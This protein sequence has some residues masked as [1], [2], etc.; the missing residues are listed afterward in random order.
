MISL[1]GT[2]I[3]RIAFSKTLYEDKGHERARVQ[4]LLKETQAM[5][6]ALFLSDYFPYMGWVDK[7]TGKI[8]RLEKNF[9]EMDVFYQ[10]IIDEH[11]DP[12]RPKPTQED[13][14]D[15]LLQIYKDRSFKVQLTFKHIK[16]ILRCKGWARSCMASVSSKFEMHL[17]SFTLNVLS[18]SLRSSPNR[19]SGT[20]REGPEPGPEHQ[21]ER[22]KA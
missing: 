20:G 11:L 18:R 6:G 4:E 8:S 21:Q 9:K 12:K 16:A 15:V 17:V 2:L 10:E 22:L 14:L 5:L 13:L 3:C 19:P 1:N 7:I